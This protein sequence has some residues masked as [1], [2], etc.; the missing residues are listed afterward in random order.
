MQHQDETCG[1]ELAA[2]AVVPEQL[3][4]LFRHVAANLRDHA[5][6][7]GTA[8]V[9]TKREHDAM[10]DV[11]H[12]YEAIGLSAQRTATLMR[13]LENLPTVSHDP[14]K[15][16]RKKFLV[17]MK[18]KIDLQRELARLLME[19]AEQ[20]ERVLQEMGEQQRSER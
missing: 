14:Q 7:V 20:S 10:M 6:W 3:A 4:A 1:Q 2:S 15:L 19:H 8:S 9:D 5:A 16:D 18:T 11:A 17:W 12:G 13:T